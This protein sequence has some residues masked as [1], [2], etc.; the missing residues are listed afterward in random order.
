MNE[1]RGYVLR[2]ILRRAITHGRLVGQTKPFLSQMVFKVRDLM[3]GAYPELEESANRIAE[4]V[5][6]EEHQFARVVAEG[7]TPLRHRGCRSNTPYVNEMS[8]Y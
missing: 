7:F 2:K 8:R 1:G 4:V 3:K 6:A 5:E